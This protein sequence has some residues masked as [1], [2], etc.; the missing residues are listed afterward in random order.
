M[1]ITRQQPR[2]G[3]PPRRNLRVSP[4]P[5][6]TADLAR[7]PAGHP[8]EESGTRA[9]YPTA[10][11]PSHDP[12]HHHHHP[13]MGLE[14]VAA[15]AAAAAAKDDLLRS[16]ETDACSRQS[17]DSESGGASAGGS[18]PLKKPRLLPAAPGGSSTPTAAGAPAS[19]PENADTGFPA[20]ALLDLA[21]STSA[22]V[23]RM[24]DTERALVHYKRR[25]RNRESAKRS[26]A[27]RQA[28]ITEIQGE[29]EALRADTAG[30]VD[31]CV[32]FASVIARQALE[33]ETV[34]KEK[35]L[36]EAMLRC[37]QDPSP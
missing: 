23:R 17:T 24:N 36:L 3:L 10:R 27:R 14:A 29:V 12:A 37:E 6:S 35:V 25:L 26:R 19:N 4:P 5:A 30:L 1:C 32:S 22:E 8:V 21:G 9:T 7:L 28:T 2:R 33:L 11:D 15:A 16:S 20:S 34:R 31:K 13:V 18:Q